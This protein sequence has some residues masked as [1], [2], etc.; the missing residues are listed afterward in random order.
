MSHI[1]NL[2]AILKAK[3]ATS[4]AKGLLLKRHIKASQNDEVT[5]DDHTNSSPESL[6]TFL[7]GLGSSEPSQLENDAS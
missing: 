2:R 3:N 5:T 1:N 6:A 7:T 4:M